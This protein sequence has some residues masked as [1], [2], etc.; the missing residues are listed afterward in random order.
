[1]GGQCDLNLSS[2]RRDDRQFNEKRKELRQFL[3]QL[4]R[5]LSLL[6]S[7]GDH[8]QQCG[9]Y[10]VLSNLYQ[11]LTHREERVPIHVLLGGED[12]LK[13]EVLNE[14]EPN[15]SALECMW[16]SQHFRQ[17]IKEK[18]EETIKRIPDS[19]QTELGPSINPQAIEA[20]LFASSKTKDEYL[21][22]T[23]R[24]IVHFKHLIEEIQRQQNSSHSNQHLESGKMHST[25]KRKADKFHEESNSK[26]KKVDV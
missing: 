7:R 24:V 13:R 8:W 16:K 1:M 20:H 18:L 19:H 12:L 10:S 5:H 21:E 6:R 22:L 9:T 15:D 2:H 17:S 14:E 3:P 4:E 23:A 26:M 11:T 25:T